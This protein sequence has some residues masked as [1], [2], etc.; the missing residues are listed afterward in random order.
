MKKSN[1]KSIYIFLALLTLVAGSFATAQEAPSAKPPANVQGKW[2]FYCNDPSGRTSSK[3]IEIQQ[4]GNTLKGHFKGP[5]QS[6]GIE[7]TIEEQHIV[8][9][10]KTRTVLTFRG[11]VE[12]D[13]IDGTFHAREGTGTFQGVR[14]SN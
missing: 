12:G 14:T 8:F 10:T 2:T 1:C 5:N 4:D 11:R 7:G 13:K 3:Y 6:G 9:R